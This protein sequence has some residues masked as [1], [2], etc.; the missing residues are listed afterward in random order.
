MTTE[1]PSNP[2]KRARV[3]SPYLHAARLPEGDSVDPRTVIQGKILEIEIGPGRGSFLYERANVSP[4]IAILGLEVRKKWAQIVD[5]RLAKMGLHG[6]ARSLAEDAK[7]AL[8]RLKPDG[9]FAR[10]Y[11]HFPDPWWKKKHTKRLVMGDLFMKQI[12]RLLADDG[13]LFIQTD[14]ED[15]AELYERQVNDSELFFTKGDQPGSAR[16]AENPFQARTPREHRAIKDGLPVHRF[17]WGKK[18]G[19]AG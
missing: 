7:E 19:A 8:P 16:I 9:I 1:N 15:R 13:E 18:L 11:L 4:D 17:L 5:E 6:R 14:V 3:P 12:H 10:A 2:P